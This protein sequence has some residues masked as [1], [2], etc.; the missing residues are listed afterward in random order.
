VPPKT[1]SEADR[2]KQKR[3]AVQQSHSSAQA[4][5][6][7]P[8]PKLDVFPTPQPLTPQEQALAVFA[9]H[10]PEPERKALAKAQQQIDAPLSIAAIHI[11]PVQSPDKG[12]N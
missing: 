9:I 7:A 4:A 5:K 3:I 8:L 11:P 2:F 1:H 10:G 6:S 12:T